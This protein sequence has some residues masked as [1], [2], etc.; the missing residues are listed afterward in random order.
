MSTQDNRQ[1][2]I[3]IILVTVI[4]SL[5]DAM[6][7]HL[8]ETYNTYMVV[9]IRFWFFGIF[10]IWL[11]A[12]KKGGLARAIRAHHPWMQAIRA[13]F[14]VLEIYVMIAAFVLLGLIETHAVFI[15]YPLL[16]AALS[17][18]VLGETVG[19]RRWMAIGIGFIGVMIIL[20]PSNGV[21]APEAAIPFAAALM[22]AVY[23]LLT[24]KVADRDDA[25]V[26]IFWTGVGGAVVATLGGMW[27]WEPMSTGDWG[28]MALLCV[29]AVAGHGLMIRA[30][31]VAEA[32]AIQPFSY[33]QLVWGAMLGMALFG[34]ILRPNVA[35]GACFVVAAGLF[36][37][38][39][40]RV[41][42]QEPIVPPDPVIKP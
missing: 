34:D 24:R 2:A 1:G 15:C 12:R 4:F 21:F 42:N 14:L 28:W 18:P 35:I 40:Q 8:A 17:G 3:L 5:Q 33:L 30:Y 32:S 19:W 7:R 41:K 22:F 10:A 9:M 37:L 26:S 16:V 23:A 27:F 6:S 20:K 38:W 39:R 29:A 11:A 25:S 36:T 31:E 13:V